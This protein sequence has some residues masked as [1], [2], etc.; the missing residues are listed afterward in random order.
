MSTEEVSA[1]NVLLYIPNL[2]GYTRV[3]MTVVAYFYALPG[4]E[5]AF[6]GLM[7]WQV[8]LIC[9]SISFVA[10]AIDGMAAR[11]FKQSSDFGAVLDMVTDRCST[12]GFLMLLSHLYVR[13]VGWL[14]DWLAG[15]LAMR[16][17]AFP[18]VALASYMPRYSVLF[19]VP[20]LQAGVDLPHGA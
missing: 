9:Y 5:E 13:T 10:D 20:R 17:M 7:G 4:D 15:W 8:C 16:L 2:I 14:A 18:A 1:N 6:L 3:L 12:A 19:Q 11:Y